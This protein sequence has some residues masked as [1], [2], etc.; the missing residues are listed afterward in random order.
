MST[1]C[2]TDWASVNMRCRVRIDAICVTTH[3]V[4][5]TVGRRTGGD[6]VAHVGVVARGEGLRHEARDILALQL[7]LGVAQHLDSVFVGHLDDTL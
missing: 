5:I 7:A 4:R 6:V 2:M 3:M 1:R